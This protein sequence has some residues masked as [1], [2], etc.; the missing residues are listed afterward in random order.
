MDELSND[1]VNDI[2]GASYH[3][4]SAAAAAVMQLDNHLVQHHVD[5]DLVPPPLPP[6]LNLAA[7]WENMQQEYPMYAAGVAAPDLLNLLHLPQYAV[8]PVFHPEDEVAIAGGGLHDTSALH[9]GYTPP[10]QAQM[11][12][13]LFQSLPQNYGLFC[14]GDERDASAAAAGGGGGLMLPEMEGMMMRRDGGE[15]RRE[16]RG[17][18]INGGRCFPTERQRRVQFNEK[19]K[20]LRSLVP[21]PTK[22][23]PNFSISS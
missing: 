4:D 7:A 13:D 14:G 21:N 5:F 2:A 22:V 3:D 10:P 12:R 1:P 11:L 8:P 16:I 23:L 17:G 19:Y 15:Y 18:D 9:F 6:E 20:A